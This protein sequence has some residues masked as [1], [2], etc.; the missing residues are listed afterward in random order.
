MDYLQFRTLDAMSMGARNN[1]FGFT[2]KEKCGQANPLKV[3]CGSGIG[4]CLAPKWNQC[5][6]LDEDLDTDQQGEGTRWY[7]IG[8]DISN[9]RAPEL[10]QGGWGF[11]PGML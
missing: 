5:N 6:G 7:M 9:T 10:D 2:D 8:S 4:Q 1:V 11:V 3:D